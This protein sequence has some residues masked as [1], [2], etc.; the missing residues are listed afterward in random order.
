MGSAASAAASTT[1]RAELAKPSDASDLTG[2][3]LCSRL[4]P[5]DGSN[6]SLIDFESAKAEVVRLRA[7]A[8]ELSQTGSESA[9]MVSTDSTTTL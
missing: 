3:F 1:I 6:L 8:K 2:A 7:L 5:L 4:S 9:V